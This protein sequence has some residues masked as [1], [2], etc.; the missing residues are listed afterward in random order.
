MVFRN[1]QRWGVGKRQ[2]DIHL[3]IKDAEKA[4]ETQKL[5]TVR[6]GESNPE[7]LI[8]PPHPQALHFC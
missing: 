6:G 8:Q 3:Q 2:E 1:T 4:R 5:E 7:G